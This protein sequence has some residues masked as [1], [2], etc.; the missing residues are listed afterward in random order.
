MTTNKHFS[1][2]DIDALPQRFR[3]NF[4]NCLSGFKSANLV[5]TQ[6]AEGHLNLAVISSVV[7]LGANPPL[8]GMIMRPHTV[9]RD[10][11]ENITAT[12]VYTINH[13]A[14]DW[15]D[16]A[17]QT[18]ARYEADESEFD[19]VGLT[20]EYLSDFAAPF[21]QQSPIKLGMRFVE[22]VPITHNDTTLLIGEIQHVLLPES[23]VTEDGHVDLNRCDIACISGLDNYHKPQHIARYSYAKPDKSLEKLLP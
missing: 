2:R 11:I 19:T 20:P 9:R 10:T 16:K 17:H 3:A 23:A 7:H 14:S 5:G 6:N 15:V 18:S 12:G 22:S 13:I 21:V 4:I 8:L 1:K